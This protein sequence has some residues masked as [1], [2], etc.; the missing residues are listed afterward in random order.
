MAAPRR[1]WSVINRV[2]RWDGGCCRNCGEPGA[3]AAHIIERKHDANRPVRWL[4]FEW[5]AKWKP[6]LVSPD[7]VILLCGPATTTSTCHGMYDGHRLDILKYLSVEQQ[8]QAVAD[9][10]GIGLALRR[11]SPTTL[12]VP[13]ASEVEVRPLPL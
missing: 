13:P 9:A 3:E 1:D 12:T 11:I 10:S 5:A 6:Y 7:R 8:V 2:L 4:E